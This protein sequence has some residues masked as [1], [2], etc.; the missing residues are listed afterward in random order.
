[1]RNMVFLV[2]TIFP[3]IVESQNEYTD[4]ESEISI[5]ITNLQEHTK[6]MFRFTEARI[7]PKGL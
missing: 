4:G 3:I 1:M 2:N 5:G 7:C 6:E